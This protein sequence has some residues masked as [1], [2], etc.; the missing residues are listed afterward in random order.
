MQENIVLIFYYSTTYL[1]SLFKK[2]TITIIIIF[3]KKFTSKLLFTLHAVFYELIEKIR[4]YYF[5]LKRN[6]NNQIRGVESEVNS[7]V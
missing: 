7:F 5:Y 2:I 1:P 4:D 6:I 3:K